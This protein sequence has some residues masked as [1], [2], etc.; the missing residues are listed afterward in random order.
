VAQ[1]RQTR[2]SDAPAKTINV[3]DIASTSDNQE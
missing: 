1:S 3:D 2:S